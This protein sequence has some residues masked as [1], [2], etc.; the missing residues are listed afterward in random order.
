M[1]NWTTSEWLAVF[2][3]ADVAAMPCHTLESLRTD[4]H[5][6]AVKLLTREQHLT[7]GIV[8]AIRSTIR[9]DDAYPPP[10]DQAQPKGWETRTVLKEIGFSTEEIDDLLRSG[11]AIDS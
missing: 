3:A 8:S 5:L 9:R 7:E 1:T 10:G 11:A 2:E 6:E 4:P